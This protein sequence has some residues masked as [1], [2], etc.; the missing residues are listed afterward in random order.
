MKLSGED[1][2]LEGEGPYN[3]I[4]RNIGIEGN[5]IN[6]PGHTEDG[7]SVILDNG[8]IFPGDNTMNLWSFNLLGIKK[9]PIVYQ[10]MKLIYDSWRIYMNNGGKIIFPAHGKPFD[11]E[12]LN[13]F[14]D[15][16]F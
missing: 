14:I 8:F 10:D 11:I 7:I 3:E 4:L 9:R 12:K 2:I 1:I 13:K 6:S 16:K 15:L 5:I